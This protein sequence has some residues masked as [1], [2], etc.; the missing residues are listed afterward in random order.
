MTSLQSQMVQLHKSLARRN[1]PHAFGGALAL[2]WCTQ[3]A[4]GTID[5]DINIFISTKEIDLLTSALPKAIGTSEGNLKDLHRD[6]Q[7]R[8]MWNDTPL[9]IFLN[10]TTFHAQAAQRIRYETFAGVE[11]PFLACRDLA[12]F[13]TFFNRTRDWADLEEMHAAG[14]LDVRAVTTELLE[15]LGEDDPRI[16]RLRLLTIK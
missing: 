15:F 12:V 9:D 3:Q 10:T 16:M 1:I 7:T 5:I 11:L 14:T 4:R 8:L 6:G 2:A 13:K